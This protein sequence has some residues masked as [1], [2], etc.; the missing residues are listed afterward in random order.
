MIRRFWKNIHIMTRTFKYKKLLC[1]HRN[2]FIS[3]KQVIEWLMSLGVLCKWKEDIKWT[4]FPWSYR[5]AFINLIKE[6]KYAVITAYYL[7]FDVINFSAYWNIDRYIYIYKVMNTPN[8]LTGPSMANVRLNF[9][10]Y[11]PPCILHIWTI[12]IYFL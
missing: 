12:E 7:V 11:F 10:L 6:R 5:S 4:C 9:N 3:E 2:N 1:S 8:V